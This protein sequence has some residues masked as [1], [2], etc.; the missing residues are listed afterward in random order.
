MTNWNAR[1]HTYEELRTLV[2]D[3]LLARTCRKFDE[4]QE[5]VGQAILKQNN[6]WP[7]PPR[8][9]GIAYQG[10]VSYLHPYDSST[11]LEVFW[12][13]FRQGV[14]T[15][16]KDARNPGWPWF[17]LSRF[18]E[19]IKNQAAF[20]FHDTSS[21]IAMIKAYDPDISAAGVLYLEEAAAS[22]YAEC[23]LSAS[24]MLGVAAEAEFL[25]VLHVATSSSQWGSIFA[26]VA[27]APFIRGKIQQFQAA[28][29]PH[30][31]NLPHE[32][33]EDLDTNLSMIQSVLRIARNDAGHPSG[34][35][36]L[37]REQVY[38]NM[39]LFGPF[40]RQLAGLRNALA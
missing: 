18:G 28:I 1:Q 13:L 15:L 14:I 27:K 35:P 7:R 6:Q 8:E 11:I 37:T 33:I 9:T 26:S 22:F 32:L 10:A 4:L 36:A 30:R 20:R 25:R 31:K 39:Q 21:Y 29:A 5:K 23:L 38:V 17:R 3:E 34:R 16:G 24:V 2:I 19:N 40:A 12:D